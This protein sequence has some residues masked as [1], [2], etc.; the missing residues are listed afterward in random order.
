MPKSKEM[1]IC[2]SKVRKLDFVV[3]KYLVSCFF[4]FQLSTRVVHVVMIFV[5]VELGN[6]TFLV[7]RVL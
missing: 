6:L 3:Y 2:R 5:G 4:D 7:D 1:I